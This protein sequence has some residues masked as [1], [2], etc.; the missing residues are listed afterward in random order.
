MIPDP[1]I[2]AAF[3][4]DRLEDSRAGALSPFQPNMDA[5]N[6]R[7][8]TALPLSRGRGVTSWPVDPPS[9]VSGNGATDPNL[10][11]VPI[12]L[13]SVW[14]CPKRTVLGSAFANPV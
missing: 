14:V 7:R 1:R 13:T 8:R 11:R 12:Q 6:G 9:S 2:L 3:L 10:P 5:P 4:H